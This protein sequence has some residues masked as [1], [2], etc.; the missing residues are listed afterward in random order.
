MMGREAPLQSK[1]FYT[2]FNLERRI[3]ANHPLRHIA[4]RGAVKRGRESFFDRAWSLRPNCW[5]S[6]R[7][8]CHAALLC[9]RNSEVFADFLGEQVDNLGMAWYGRSLV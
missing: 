3:R 8:H 7:A 4:Q 2:D 5:K 9:W 6:F 1:L